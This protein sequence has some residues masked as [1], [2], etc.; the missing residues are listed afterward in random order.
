MHWIR[1]VDLSQISH[2]LT[3]TARLHRYQ[4]QR[5]QFQGLPQARDRLQRGR[6][7]VGGSLTQ[8]QNRDESRTAI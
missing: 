6:V 8:I 4:G 7:E 3:G 5:I 1:R 2:A